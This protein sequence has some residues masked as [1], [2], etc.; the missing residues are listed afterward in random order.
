M[1]GRRGR[2][3]ANH[4]LRIRRDR[5][6]ALPD[7]KWIAFSA[8]VREHKADPNDLPAKVIDDLLFRH[9]VEWR[10]GVRTHTYLANRASGA[11]HRVSDP[12]FD[13][14][15]FSLE[16]RFPMRSPPIARL[17]SIPRGPRRTRRSRPTSICTRRRSTAGRRRGD[18]PAIRA[19]TAPP[20]PSPD[21]CRY[22]AFRSQVT[23]GYE[24]DLFT[25]QLLDL[26]TGAITRRGRTSIAGSTR[27][28]GL[29]TR[30][31]FSWEP[32]TR[33]PT[34]CGASRSRA[35]SRRCLRANFSGFQLS[36][37]A[38]F[39][40]GRLA[41][42]RHSGRGGALR[43]RRPGL[44]AV[45]HLNDAFFKVKGSARWS[46]CGSTPRGVPAAKDGKIQGWLVKPPA[47]KAG[48]SIRSS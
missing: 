7:G 2:S 27:W 32:K 36:P 47:M 24:S 5:A 10:D 26:K 22:V 20:A 23:P 16:G 35:P 39:L 9:W 42:L 1:R 41:S 15:G 18:S 3:Q 43:G 17:F 38:A 46:R 13:A 40:V 6:G 48:S 28:C 30:S 8:D 14:P 31:R 12:R 37:D 34:R 33:G 21:G 44:A 25:L 4:Q 29:P 11:R 45:T 19:G